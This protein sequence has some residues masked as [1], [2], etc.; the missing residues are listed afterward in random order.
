MA[1]KKTIAILGATSDAGS[2]VAR[3]LA[4]SPYQLMLMSEDAQDLDSLHKSIM[5]DTQGTSEVFSVDCAKEASWEADIIVVA[6]P[7]DRL[8]EVAEKIRDVS[9][10]KVVICMSGE[11]SPSY[12]GVLTALR[13]SAAEELQRLLP[14]SSVV[15]T[16]NTRFVADFFTPI[17]DG[18]RVDVLLA[19][20][21]SEAVAE[22]QEIVKSVGFNAVVVGHL[23]MSGTLDDMQRII[24]K[25]GK[26]NYVWIAGWK[27][28]DNLRQSKAVNVQT[29]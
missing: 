28:I 17:I 14:H 8:N 4:S 22:V 16:L 19:G 23:D 20:N 15:K 3:R 29:A 1:L 26:Y 13:S 6:T 9:V 25:L 12:N 24:A 10:G 2:A 21:S 7:Y 5:D 27:P 11:S 18:K